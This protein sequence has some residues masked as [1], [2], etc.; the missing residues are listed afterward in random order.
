MSVRRFFGVVL[1]A[2]GVFNVVMQ[3][4]YFVFVAALLHRV[5]LVMLSMPKMKFTA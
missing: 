5:D 1:A 3:K 4:L 2:A